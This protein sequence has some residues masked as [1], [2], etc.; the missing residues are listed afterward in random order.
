[1]RPDTTHTSVSAATDNQQ[2]HGI[3]HSRPPPQPYQAATRQ[4]SHI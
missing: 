2:H 3:P 4:T 1:M